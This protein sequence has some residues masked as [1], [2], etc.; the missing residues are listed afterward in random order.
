[1]AAGYPVFGAQV[2]QVQPAR[3]VQPGGHGFQVLGGQLAGERLD[4]HIGHLHGLPVLAPVAN[5]H[6]QLPLAFGLGIGLRAQRREY[7][8]L[9]HPQAHRQPM[10]GHQLASQ[11]P[12]NA[13]IAKVIDDVAEDVPLHDQASR[14]K[15][16]VYRRRRAQKQNARH[17]GGPREHGAEKE[18]RGRKPQATSA[19]R[20]RWRRAISSSQIALLAPAASREMKGPDRFTPSTTTNQ[21]AIWPAERRASGT[22][23]PTRDMTST[24]DMT[25]SIALHG[26]QTMGVP[27]RTEISCLDSGY[28]FQQLAFVGPWRYGTAANC[29]GYTN[30]P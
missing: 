29:R 12:G 8:R 19:S 26:A 30:G 27:R 18:E 22:A 1:M 24:W 28:P 3:L 9:V 7:R 5:L 6:T 25:T 13:Y 10:F 11:A 15:I 21:Q 20:P 2:L 23:V 14:G 4:H 16:A 17:E